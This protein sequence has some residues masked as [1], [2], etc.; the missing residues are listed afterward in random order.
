MYTIILSHTP[1]E[2]EM[3]YPEKSLNKL[4]Q[5]GN[6]ILNPYD[7]QLTTKE[8]IEKAH[9]A[10]FII[11]TVR[12][13]GNEELFENCP[14]LIS[15]IRSG[16]DIR[17]INMEAAAR[18]G[19]LVCNCPGIYEAPV[20]ELV[21]GYLCAISRGIIK[22]HTELKN[23]V[24]QR[25]TLPDLWRKSLGLIGYGAI[26][27][28]VAKVA[29]ALGMKILVHDPFINEVESDEQ[30]C[31]MEEL[32]KNSDFVS[33]HAVLNSETEGMMGEKEFSLMKST[34]WFI[35]S[36]RGLLVQE[37]A[38][39]EHLVEGKIA[40]AALDV[41]ATEPNIVENP[42]VKLDN[43]IATPH[44]G[45]WSSRVYEELSLRTVELVEMMISGEMPD[46]T[47]NKNLIKENGRLE[48]LI[49]T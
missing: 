45:G 34:A 6:V 42:L 44:I 23:G 13:E 5:L 4:K 18:N 11:T 27:R 47:Y 1:K 43:V 7:R 12:F 15:F 40:G 38:L 22:H 8:M 21:I 30:L 28:K 26:A 19:V 32:L 36:G 9:E 24:A 49:H 10:N 29:K 39:Y 25:Y 16:V 46:S 2:L 37:K 3:L 35:N 48:K 41:F 14:N 33:L 31:S 17:N 20:V